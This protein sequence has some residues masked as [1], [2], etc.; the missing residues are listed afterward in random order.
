MLQVADVI[1]G[2]SGQKCVP[3]LGLAWAN[4]VTTRLQMS[5]TPHTVPDPDTG[6]EATVRTLDVTFSPH[7]PKKSCS[8]IVARSGVYGIN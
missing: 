4:M 6:L 8:F 1:N 2:E 3:V 7:L 5:R